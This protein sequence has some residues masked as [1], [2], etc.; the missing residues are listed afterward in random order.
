MT[1]STK[2]RGCRI[3]F[4]L[5]ALSVLISTGYGCASGKSMTDTEMVEFEQLGVK[6]SEKRSILNARQRKLKTAFN[7]SSIG[8]S[9]KKVRLCGLK[10]TVYKTGKVPLVYGAKKRVFFTMSDGDATCRSARVEVKK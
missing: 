2:S 3:R 4:G 10:H 5:F 6:I 8:A 9:T 1:S 7:R